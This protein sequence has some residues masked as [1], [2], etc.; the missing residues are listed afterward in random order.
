MPQKISAGFTIVEVMIFLAVSG[1]LLTAGVLLFSGSARRNQFS[2]A[3][4]DFDAKIQ[5]IINDTST[6]FFDKLQ[7]N[8]GRSYRCVGGDGSPPE[9]VLDA[10][11]EQGTNKDCIFIGKA[12]LLKP[13]GQ[14][15]M[16]EV[17]P[18][19]GN[20]RVGGR[21][22]TTYAEASPTT[23]FSQAQGINLATPYEIRWNAS[24]KSASPSFGGGFYGSLA[25]FGS[26]ST[27]LPE[28]G[29][30]HVEYYQHPFLTSGND[31][32]LNLQACIEILA[33]FGTSP[34]V[35]P[36]SICLQSAD[37]RQ[38]AVLSIGGSGTLT[39][40]LEFKAC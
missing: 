30:Q 19:I 31:T 37:E 38:F 17:I 4:R 13:S 11:A 33:C 3:A 21:D 10:T 15:T 20:R 5:D 39:T 24:V 14:A 18:V 27:T 1:A 22:V 28:A 32:Q 36:W 9:L 35:T 34:A 23:A 26:A 12:V 29:A 8:L 6:G 2:L 40:K 25:R 7:D 16:I